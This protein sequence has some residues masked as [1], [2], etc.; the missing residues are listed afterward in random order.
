MANTQVSGR[1]GHAIKETYQNLKASINSS[2]PGTSL[3]VGARLQANNDDEII[4]THTNSVINIMKGSA[5]RHDHDLNIICFSKSY[6]SACAMADKVFE[7][8]S[9]GNVVA[10]QNDPDIEGVFNPKSQIMYYTDEDDY[11]V[12]V[13]VTLSIIDK[14]NL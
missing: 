8:F 7:N 4:I 13:N 3:S 11:A 1:I 2:F 12:S 10:V 14:T 9:I 5:P 6:V